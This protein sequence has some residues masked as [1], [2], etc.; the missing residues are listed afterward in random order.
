GNQWRPVVTRQLLRLRRW[1]L[2]PDYSLYLVEGAHLDLAHALAR[3][4][5][6][7][8]QVLERDRIIRQPPRLEDAALALIEHRERLAERLAAVVAFL[9]RRPPVLLV[10]GPLHPPNL[11]LP[12]IALPPH[13]GALG[14]VCA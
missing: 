14:G 10:G 11:P 9:A 3:D 7:G 13:H 4:P 1:D 2:G 8:G 12:R 6:L 5:E